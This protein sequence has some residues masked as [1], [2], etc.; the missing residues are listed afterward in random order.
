MQ[1]PQLCKT[2]FAGMFSKLV[3]TA[4]F[5]F[6]LSAHTAFQVVPGFEF[7]LSA[8]EVLKGVLDIWEIRAGANN[9][10]NKL[11]MW[12]YSICSLI[13]PSSQLC[14]PCVL[15]HLYFCASFIQSQSQLSFLCADLFGQSN[16]SMRRKSSFVQFVKSIN[17]NFIQLQK[18]LRRN[19]LRQKLLQHNLR[20]FEFILSARKVL[21]GVLEN[22]RRCKQLQMMKLQKCNIIPFVFRCNFYAGRTTPFSIM[23]KP[24]I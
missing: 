9:L 5:E 22:P 3:W 19:L 16:N 20:S 23:F 8:R 17:P 13:Q 6:I 11:T 21:Q 12:H 7:I 10:E 4:T 2:I 18:L 14:Y 1:E 24:M 15:F